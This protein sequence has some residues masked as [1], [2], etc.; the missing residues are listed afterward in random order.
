[1]PGAGRPGPGHRPGAARRRTHGRHLARKM[2]VSWAARW[3][4]LDSNRSHFP[5]GPNIGKPSKSGSRVTGCGAPRGPAAERSRPTTVQIEVP[6]ARV[7]AVGRVDDGAVVGREVGREGRARIA[8]DLALLRAVGA[9]HPQVHLRRA[10]EILREQPAVL[11]QPGGVRRV[12]RPVADPLPVVREEGA[13]VVA[14]L[15]REPRESRAVR[16]HLVDLEVAVPHRG[17]DDPPAVHRERGLGVWSQGQ[18]SRVAWKM[19]LLP[20]PDQ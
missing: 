6:A 13:A 17:E 9:H 10:H 19:I 5:S 1:M 18:P 4:R 14:R 20:S 2:F 16:V 11:G 3:P 15:V 8:R 12:V 7:V